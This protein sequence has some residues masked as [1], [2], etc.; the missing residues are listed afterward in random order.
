[1]KVL[2]ISPHYPEEMQGFTRG[3]AAVGAEVYAAGDVPEAQLPAHVRRHLRGYIHVPK[4]FDE[5]AAL[6]QLAPIAQRVGFDRIECLWEP[7]VLM[8]ASLRE[9]VG[10]PGM[11][12]D[13]V[14]GFRDKTLMK[15]RLVA[16]GV[17]VPRFA[18]VTSAAECYEAAAEIGY[19]IVIK[20]IDGAGSADTYAVKDAEGM[21]KVLA[22]LG[23]LQEANLEEF[24]EGD[25]FT[26]DTVCIDGVP[27]FES[28]T[29]YYPK[30]MDGRH[31][32]W[33]SPAQLTYAD[34]FAHPELHGGIAQGREVLRALG[35]GTGFTHMEWFRKPDGE[36]VFGEIAA[37][38][39]G[40]KLV[41]GMNYANDFD[42]FREWARAACW[43]SYEGSPAKRYN[44]AAVF[45][46]AIGQG[47]IQRIV[48]VQALRERCGDALL[49][50]DL[51]PPGKPRRDW[52][53]TL[54]GDGVIIVRHP[55]LGVCQSMMWQ[56]INDVQLYA[57]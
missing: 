36:V 35:M 14:L 13:T 42:V 27:R 49:S 41:D 39:P 9:R 51:T 47:T 29:K 34:P 24:I 55:N 17:R 21:K 8:T 11:S 2:F 48:G 25:E 7:C 54:I 46:R 26:Y 37:R 57:G 12:R 33:I 10:V 3:L 30:P 16:A 6:A 31:N 1:M 18:R 28:V 56:A 50:L 22:Q 20:P 32:E 53:N 38:A 15:Q 4:L 43:R 5:A 52:L 19:P 40:G 44:V 45:K 23:H